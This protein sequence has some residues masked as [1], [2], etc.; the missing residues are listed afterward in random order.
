[1]LIDRARHLG[2]N[3][4]QP[5]QA[6]RALLRA[7][8]LSAASLPSAAPSSDN[9]A[10]CCDLDQGQLGSCTANGWAQA[11]YMELMREGQA[12]FIPSRLANY[13]WNRN[14]DGNAAEDVGASVGGAFEVGADLGIPEEAAWPYEVARV[15]DCPTPDVYR[16]AYDRKGLVR[17]NYFPL[18]CTADIMIETIE[19]VLTSGRGI[20]F[21]CQVSEAFCSTLPSGIVQAPGPDDMI[22]GGHCMVVVGHNRDEQWFLVKNSWGEWGEPGQPPGCFRMA[23]S[24]MELASDLW[25]VSLSTG[26]LR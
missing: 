23:Y 18:D 24:Y 4:P 1:M 10:L 15:A 25:F 12:A 16:N 14:R 5:H 19:R 8:P 7:H 3:R 17:T 26:G 11:L 6:I 22:A 20:A 9:S 21:G 2:W 13:W